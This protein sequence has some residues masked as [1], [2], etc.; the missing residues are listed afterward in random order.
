[1]RVIGDRVLVALRP[2]PDELLSDG[3]TIALIRDPDILRTPTQGIV[4]QVG[5]KIGRVDL[6]DVLVD[7]RAMQMEQGGKWEL[8]EAL[9]E[10]FKKLHPATFEVQVGDCVLFS[11]FIGEEFELDGITYVILKEQD[12][13]AIV[14]AKNEVAA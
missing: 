6:E 13:L 11:R 8:F 5:E 1:M 10:G 2:E 14:D 4:T 7:C 9:I 3:G 12:I